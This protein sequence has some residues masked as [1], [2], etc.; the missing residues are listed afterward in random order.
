LTALAEVEGRGTNEHTTKPVPSNV[1][2]TGGGWWRAD[3]R[4]EVVDREGKRPHARPTRETSNGWVSG[5]AGLSGACAHEHGNVGAVAPSG[6]SGRADRRSENGAFV[7][8]GP[9]SVRILR[10]TRT[11]A[12]RARARRV[13]GCGAP[14]VGCGT[15][16]THVTPGPT[17][18]APKLD[19]STPWPDCV[20]EVGRRSHR[21]GARCRSPRRTMRCGRPRW[22]AGRSVRAP[23]PP[24]VAIASVRKWRGQHRE[25]RRDSRCTVRLPGR[26]SRAR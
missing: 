13:A 19:S 17:A 26:R 20:D 5:R 14:A 2:C 11:T 21:G 4:F 7:R 22:R 6:V 16:H 8:I 10:G 24:P 18:M 3:D 12:L 9:R 25:V 1:W 15:G 23:H